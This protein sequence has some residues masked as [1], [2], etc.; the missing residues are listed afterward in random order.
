SAPRSGR[1]GRDDD[2]QR[3][4]HGEAAERAAAQPDQRADGCEIRRDDR[5]RQPPQPLPEDD[6]SAEGSRGRVGHDDE[7]HHRARGEGLEAAGRADREQER[8]TEEEGRDGDAASDPPARAPQ[9]VVFDGAVHCVWICPAISK[10]GMYMA[11]RITPTMPPM[12]TIMIGSRSE[13]IA[14]TATSTSSS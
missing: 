14:L 1:E 13:V 5:T 11:M 8:P 9:R 6:G 7:A 3:Q 4:Q 12:K 2:V 10:M